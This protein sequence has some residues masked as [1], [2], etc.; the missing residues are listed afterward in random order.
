[1]SRATLLERRLQALESDVELEKREHNH[2][3]GVLT[4]V[5]VG[6]IFSIRFTIL[7]L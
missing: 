5:K 1:M 7:L 6:N 4:G 2:T 3:K